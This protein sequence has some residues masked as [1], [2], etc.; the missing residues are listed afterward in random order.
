MFTNH[1][2]NAYSGCHSNRLNKIVSLLP[3]ACCLLLV[4][5]CLWP[6]A[7]GLLPVAYSLFPIPY[8]LQILPQK[9]FSDCFAKSWVHRRC[10]K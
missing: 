1:I 10:N 3:V 6:V 9:I 5:C 4:A 8:S 2:K 7:C